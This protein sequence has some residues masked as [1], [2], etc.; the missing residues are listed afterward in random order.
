MCH[1]KV[2]ESVDDE[3]DTFIHSDNI[4]HIKQHNFIETIEIWGPSFEIKFDLYLSG[5]FGNRYSNIL[6]FQSKKKEKVPGLYFK[7]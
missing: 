3:E 2:L 5:F 6:C 1:T 4:I 7:K